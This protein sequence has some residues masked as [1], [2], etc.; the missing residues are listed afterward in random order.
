MS[1]I[2]LRGS[3][4]A[5]GPIGMDP[6]WQNITDPVFHY[7][8][9]RPQAVAFHEGHFSLT[10][11]ALAPLVGKAAVCLDG[12]GIRAGDPV[13]ICLTNSIDHFILTLGLLRLGATVMEIPYDAQQAPSAELLAKFNICTVF[14]EPNT[15]PVEGIKSVRVDGGWRRQIEQATGDLRHSG[16]GDDIFT[17]TLT[18][19]TTGATKGSLTSHR[20]YFQRLRAYEEL[21]AP[22]GVF[23]SE[24]PA[25]FLLT[26]SIGY[27]T[28]FRRMVSHLFI[29]GSV[30]IL[31]E[32]FYVLDL[33]KAIAAWENAYCFVPSAFCRVLIGCAPAQ[34]V[35]FPRLRALVT[36]GGFLYAEE[37]LAMLSRVTPHFYETYGASGFGTLSVLAPGA[38]RERGASVGRPPSS[39]DVQVIGR[40]GSPLP[41]GS[42]GRLRCRGTESKG[43]VGD[44]NL[45]GDERFRDG[46][47]YPGDFA[48]LDAAGYIYLKG[49]AAD[50]IVRRKGVEV[51]AYDIEQSLAAH[52]SVAEVAIVGVPRPVPGE[53]LVAVVVPRGQVRH[54]ALVSHCR[55]SLPADHWPD[56]VFYAQSLPKTS[57]GKLDRTRVRELAMTEIRRQLG[58][59][60]N[61]PEA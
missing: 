59:A 28:F 57:A 18:S 44:T 5:Y 12:L 40:D 55:A 33:V 45:E 8:V 24:K 46:W 48:E 42:V 41:V 2:R 39:V 7:A 58:G 30:A 22:T 9:E 4:R 29:G 26:S 17:I 21:L 34:D 19:G 6:R 27:S 25:V 14:L 52:P 10:Y 56:R 1:G 61:V 50:V 43:F 47:Y 37:K 3:P 20:R 53:E 51:F 23:S 11:G 31:P 54:E 15:V 16:T 13:G 36:G 60:R 32:F 38:M 35:L 49:R